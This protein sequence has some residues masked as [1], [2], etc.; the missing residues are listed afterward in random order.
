MPHG[1]QVGWGK[2]EVGSGGADVV[3]GPPLRHSLGGGVLDFPR[4]H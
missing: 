1:Y 4:L 2:G 3:S